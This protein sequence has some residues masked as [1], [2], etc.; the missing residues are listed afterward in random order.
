MAISRRTLMGSMGA[1]VLGAGALSGCGEGGLRG[2]GRRKK[3]TPPPSADPLAEPDQAL[4][5]GSLGSAHG[6][7]STF[8]KQI[9]IAVEE[10]MIDVNA[11][12]EGLFGH[13]VTMVP[14]H[15]MADPG[16]DISQA[17]AALADQGVTAVISS[18]DEDALLAALPHFVEAD[19]AVIDVFTSGMTLRGPEVDAANML[20]RLTPNNDIIATMIVDESKSGGNSPRVGASGTIVYVSEETTQGKDLKDRIV[21][22]G[23]PARVNVVAEHFYPF[24]EIGDIGAIVQKVVSAHPALLVVNSGAEAGPLL[25]ALYEAALDEG[26]RPT[27]EI[28]VRLSP[29]ATVDYTKDELAPECL[30]RATGWEP[31]GELT[32]DHINMMLDRDRNLLELGY[33]YSQQAYDAVV[34][35][36]LAAQ[37]GLS[38]KGSSIAANVQKVLTGDAECTDYGLCRQT[39][40]DELVDGSRGTIAYQGRTGALEVGGVGDAA[41]GSMRTYTFGPAG[42]LIAGSATTFDSSQ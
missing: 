22:F 34:L 24:G 33:A 7:S 19:I 5:L 15:V 3:T 17:V 18:L 20:T 16:E 38:T 9:S 39:L 36:C 11:R 40:R 4:V 30:T 21:H 27:I 31:G 13:D 25:S 35:A 41:K 8:E 6:R 32:D 12:W 1:S 23:N 26:N 37:N 29:A 2:R 10:A 28:P 42:A 14:R